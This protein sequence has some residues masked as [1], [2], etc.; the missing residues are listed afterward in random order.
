MRPRRPATLPEGRP[1]SGDDVD[2]GCGIPGRPGLLGDSGCGFT[3]PGL[4]GATVCGLS[5]FGGRGFE[6]R[7][8]TGM[9]PSR[10]AS[11]AARRGVPAFLP[12]PFGSFATPTTPRDTAPLVTPGNAGIGTPAPR[13][14]T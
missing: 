14:G 3:A 7:D 10:P 12:S 5:T 6:R 9:R 8:G 13:E 4:A 11:D 2:M 1:L